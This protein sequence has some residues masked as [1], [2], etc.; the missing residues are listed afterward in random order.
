MAISV[1][2]QRKVNRGNIENRVQNPV[3]IH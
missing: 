3:L 1:Q 2:Q